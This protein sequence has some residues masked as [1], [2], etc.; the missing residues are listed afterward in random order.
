[1]A[2]GEGDAAGEGV[3]AGLGL[4]AGVLSLGAVGEDATAGDGVAVPEPFELSAGSQ[5]AANMIEKVARSRIAARL[6]ELMLVV[7]I[8]LPRSK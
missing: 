5:P 2:F 4:L 6:M 8:S 1:M 3:T 7:F